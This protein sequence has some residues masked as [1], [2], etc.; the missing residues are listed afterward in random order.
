MYESVLHSFC[1]LKIFVCNFLAYNFSKISAYKMFMKMTT[2]LQRKCKQEDEKDDQ[3]GVNIFEDKE[4]LIFK[5]LHL[6]PI[7]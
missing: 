6:G 1:V 7:L 2:G 3:V 4:L 5:Y